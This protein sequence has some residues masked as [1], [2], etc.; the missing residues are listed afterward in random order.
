MQD[1]ITLFL[2]FYNIS[3][4]GLNVNTTEYVSS[5]DEVDLFGLFMVFLDESR[6]T[7]QL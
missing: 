7:G 4:H 3:L 5:I 1:S 6:S 2:H